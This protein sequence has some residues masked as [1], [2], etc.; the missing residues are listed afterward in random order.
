MVFATVATALVVGLTV[1][2]WQAVRARNAEQA[3]MEKAVSLGKNISPEVMAI[4]VN[5]EDAGRLADLAASNLD[6]K[7]EDAQSV[8][9]LIDQNARLRR[10]NELLTNALKHG[11]KDGRHGTIRVALTKVSDGKLRL[12][13]QDD[14]VGLPVGFDI[15]KVSSMGLQLVCTLSEQLD[16]D[17]VV[18]GESGA[19]FQLTF[20]GND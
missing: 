3:A 16:A 6:L 7:V 9:D 2:I 13:V 10:V 19:A 12:T 8:L 11:F 4:A 20:A 18:S 15:Q 1:S 5:L 14:G 17:L